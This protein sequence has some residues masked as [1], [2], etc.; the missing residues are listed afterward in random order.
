MNSLAA[1]SAILRPWYRAPAR[2]FSEGCRDPS[3]PAIV[4]AP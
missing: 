3:P 4:V 2:S 1:T